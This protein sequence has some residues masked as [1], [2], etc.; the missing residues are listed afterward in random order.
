MA[1]SGLKKLGFGRFLK[2][3]NIRRA[4]ISAAPE[5]A[6]PVDYNVNRIA[7]AWHP[8]KQYM[9]IVSV[10]E[11][12]RDAKSFVLEPDVA[13]G[14]K[15]CAYF[16][17][18][19]YLSV[20][21]KPGK[22][23]LSRPYSISSSPKEGREGKYEI[24][25]K[26]VDGG[27]CSNYILDNWKVGDE[28]TVSAPCGNF[29]YE[30]LRDAKTVIGIA[31]GSGITP[32]VSLAKAIADGDE[33][34]NLTILYGCKSLD[35]AI[36]RKELEEICLKCESVKVAYVLS[37]SE[38]EGCEKG[39]ITA[40]LIKK[41]APKKEQYS[42]FLCGPQKMYEFVDKEVEKLN[43]ERKFVR[44]ELFGEIHAPSGED[45]PVAKSEKVKITA[46]VR[47]EKFEIT[48][49]V[50]D[51]IMVSL[52]N[53]GLAVPARCRSGVCG[54]CHSRLIEGEVYIPKNVDG[55]RLADF[56]YGYVHPCCTFPLTDVVL[57][58]PASK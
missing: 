51:S 22:T 32:F 18:G 45:Y 9:R 26:R 46:I 48:A 53:S 40:E 23:D 43:I 52:E 31:G 47:D 11:R 34:A 4:N 14:T 8:S 21:L 12:G 2:L 49:S 42:V 33:E 7:A 29:T 15:I 17:A 10:A 37:D 38:A 30:P 56:D 55:R 58:I 6:L 16:S 57:E 39:F 44:H 1:K 19:Q 25:V 24:T 20:F 5:K 28:V 35:E 41:Y 13:K 3:G 50:E 36:F 54:F 27:L